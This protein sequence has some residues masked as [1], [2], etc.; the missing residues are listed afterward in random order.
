MICMVACAENDSERGDV[1]GAMDG[2][3]AFEDARWV[4]DSR[5]TTIEDMMPSRDMTPI[6]MDGE[7]EVLD[8]TPSY[9]GSVD[10]ALST[11]MASNQRDMLSTLDVSVLELDIGIETDLSVVPMIDDCFPEQTNANLSAVEFTA[12]PNMPGSEVCNEAAAGELD[13]DLT[14]LGSS[15]GAPAIID[16]QEVTACVRA[17]FGR[18]CGLNEHVGLLVS[19]GMIAQACDTGTDNTTQQCD[20]EALCGE[21]PGA[22]VLLFVAAEP[23]DVRFVARAGQCGQGTAL[24]SLTPLNAFSSVV[25]LTAVRYVYACRPSIAC[26]PDAADVSVD[27]MYLIWR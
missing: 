23:N 26:G 22:S 19:S 11:D 17:D 24:H 9:D 3:Q 4:P 10:S 7:M 13:G 18:L 14:Q 12:M 8:V 21:R 27:A 6:S 20:V 15:D 16:G 1:V 25:D 5:G 2:S